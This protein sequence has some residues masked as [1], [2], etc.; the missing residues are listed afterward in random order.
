[1]KKVKVVMGKNLPTRSPLVFTCV[2]YLMLSHFNADG[3]MYGCFFT[4]AAIFW[5]AFFYSFFI[6]E[7]K[8]IFE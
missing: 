5:I 2:G 3:W 8:D 1:M 4:L 6:Q 7:A